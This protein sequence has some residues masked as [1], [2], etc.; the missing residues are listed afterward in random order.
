MLISD[1]AYGNTVST[2]KH[3]SVAVA[4]PCL[5]GALEQIGACD[6]Q[7]PILGNEADVDAQDVIRGSSVDE[8]LAGRMAPCLLLR[9]LGDV[10]G[11]GVRS[12]E[13]EFGS[14]PAVEDD[15]KSAVGNLVEAVLE[16]A[17]VLARVVTGDCLVGG[18]DR[19]DA[20]LVE[21]IADR[22]SRLCVPL[23]QVVEA[24]K[25]AAHR[26]GGEGALRPGRGIRHQR[27]PPFP[28][29][30]ATIAS[31]KPSTKRLR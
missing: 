9:V 14:P 17:Q 29:T 23:R 16:L 21:K 13:V 10:V 24:V 15:G 27:Y 8:L 12:G 25:D 6:R 22:A 18:V 28:S 20:V 2:E 5:D 26:A 7:L 31:T 11:D 1:L 19:R 3:G 4:Q 30:R